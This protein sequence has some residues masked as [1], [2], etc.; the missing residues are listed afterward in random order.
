MRSGNPGIRRIKGILL[1]ALAGIYSTF[2]NVLVQFIITNM[3]A[4]LQPVSFFLVRSVY[5]AAVSVMFL[6]V[7]QIN[8]FP[9]KRAVILLLMS[10]LACACGILF[11]FIALDKIPVGDVTVIFLTSPI[12]TVIMGFFFLKQ[13]CSTIDIVC[14]LFN[15]AGIIVM[16]QPSFLFGKQEASSHK[17]SKLLIGHSKVLN[18]PGSRDYVIGVVYSLLGSLCFAVFYILTQYCSKN[19]DVMVTLFYVGIVGTL[20]GISISVASIKH[21]TFGNNW[22]VW[23]LLF[24]VAFLSFI[25]VLFIAEALLLEEAGTCAV[26]RNAD[27]IYA[28]VLQYAILKVPPQVNT[29]TGGTVVV[30]STTGLA[31]YRY[32]NAK[33]RAEDI[34][35]L[36]DPD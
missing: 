1:M 18:M 4:P 33:N 20:M 35:L 14:V 8:P 25:H 6:L 24:F 16:T 29:L 28:F 2:G 13:K 9:N 21:L 27:S 32:F 5:T 36:S 34:N 10:A 7:A 3:N 22:K 17:M 30:I 26:I 15:S 19:I 11:V 12:M 23:I 31:I